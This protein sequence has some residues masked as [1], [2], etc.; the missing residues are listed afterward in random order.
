MWNNTVHSL[1]NKRAEYDY[2]DDEHKYERIIS[3]VN[4]ALFLVF[5]FVGGHP[6]GFHY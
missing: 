5:Q 2:N 1:P 4:K 6:H 3:G